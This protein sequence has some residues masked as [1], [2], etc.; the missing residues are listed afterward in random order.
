MIGIFGVIAVT[1]AI[2]VCVCECACVFVWGFCFAL[3]P[4]R[5]AVL[6][7][8]FLGYPDL[9]STLTIPLMYHFL[10]TFWSLLPAV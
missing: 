7:E 8:S 2:G 10:M 1:D 5:G 6:S 9:V 3:L 4:S